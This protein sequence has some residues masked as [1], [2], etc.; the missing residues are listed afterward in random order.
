M[1]S[2]WQVSGMPA[3]IRLRRHPFVDHPEQVASIWP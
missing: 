1:P 2:G 3:T